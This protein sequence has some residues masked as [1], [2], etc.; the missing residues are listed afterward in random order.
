MGEQAHTRNV[1]AAGKFYGESVTW[2][3]EVIWGKLLR[4]GTQSQR[5]NSVADGER[6]D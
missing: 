2:A 5:K 1:G 3:S 4:V 6:K